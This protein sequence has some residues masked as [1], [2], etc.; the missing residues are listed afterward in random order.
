MNKRKPHPSIGSDFEDFLR[1]QGRTEKAT[2]IAIKRVLA[3]DKQGRPKR[4]ART[5]RVKLGGER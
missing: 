5:A 3:M 1:D 2:A 4:A